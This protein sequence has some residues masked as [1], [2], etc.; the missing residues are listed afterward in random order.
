M[1]IVEGAGTTGFALAY[2]GGP[3]PVVRWMPTASVCA[4][5]SDSHHRQPR[6]AG[7]SWLFLRRRLRGLVGLCSVARKGP[8]HPAARG[9]AIVLFSNFTRPVA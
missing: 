9:P 8:F 1:A 6:H 2:S 4:P 3:P 7:T 5:V